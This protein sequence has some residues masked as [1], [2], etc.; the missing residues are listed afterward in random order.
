MDIKRSQAPFVKNHFLTLNVE[1]DVS[2]EFDSRS[3]FL[4]THI[5]FLWH[6]NYSTQTSM[7]G[8]KKHSAS[9]LFSEMGDTLFQTVS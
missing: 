5:C 7:I 9:G 3:L 2:A 8:N 1:K 4:R 6:C